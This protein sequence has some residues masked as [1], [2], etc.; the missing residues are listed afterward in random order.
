MFDYKVIFPYLIEVRQGKEKGKENINRLFITFLIT[1][2][3]LTEV[4]KK[5]LFDKGFKVVLPYLPQNK[6]IHAL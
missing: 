3:Y 2:N 6:G 4:M 1:S 5:S